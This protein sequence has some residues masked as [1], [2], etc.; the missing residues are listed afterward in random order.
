MRQGRIFMSCDKA[1][2]RGLCRV[3]VLIE[4]GAM[5]L[6]QSAVQTSRNSATQTATPVLPERTEREN[7]TGGGDGYIVIVY[8]NE[9][10]TYEQ[11][12]SILI[13]ATG[14]T[15]EEAEI[16]TWEVDH[17]GQSVVHHG[18]QEECERAA[19]IIRTIGIHVEVR[20]D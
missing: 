14:C 15:R 17:L 11:V 20:E 13:R 12:T 16:E 1:G 6:C 10:N 2:V 5:I 8:N 4:E 19:A 7:S 3:F 18:G 9:H